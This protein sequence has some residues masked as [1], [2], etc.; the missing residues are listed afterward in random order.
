MAYP[1][2]AVQ[3]LLDDG[4]GTFPYDLTN[5]GGTSYLLME[6]GCSY[7]R[8]REDWQGGVTAGELSGEL[9]NSDGRF[10]PGNTT[11]ASPSPITVDQKARLKF[12]IP[13]T[14]DLVNLL[15]AAQASFEDG[16]TGGW[17]AAG[18]VLPTVA[19]SSVRAYDG[20][21]SLLV[22]WQ[23][24]GS[25]P[26]AQL[27]PSG[28]TIG[29]TYTFAVWVYVPSGSPDVRCGA[30]STVSAL[31]PLKDQWVRLSVTFVAASTT[32]TFFVRSSGTPAGATCYIDAAMVVAGSTIGDFNTVAQTTY[33]RFT[34]H[35]KSWPVA[36]PAT[37]STFATVRLSATDAQARAERRVLRSV[38]EEEILEDSPSAYYTLGEPADAVSAGDTS[39]AQAPALTQTGTGTNV[40]FGS[41]TGPGTD[42]LTAATFAG[43]QYL[44]SGTSITTSV[45]ECFFSRSGAPG[46][47]EVLLGSSGGGV[48]GI[49][50][51]GKIH[52]SAA[53]LSSPV[54]T[55]GATHHL[56]WQ[57]GHVLLDGVDI[58]S[59]TSTPSA[60]S[61]LTVGY[62][63]GAAGGPSAVFS[64]VIAHVAAFS[65]L[66]TTRG[67]A[68]AT[69]GSTG[70]AG[71]SG[72][73]RIT[74][75]AGYA[76]LPVGTLDTSLTNVAFIDFTNSEAWPTLQDAVDAEGG[77]AFVNGS[78]NLTFHNRNKVSLKTAPDLTLDKAYV[79]AD[80][81]P[82]TDDQQILNYVEAT[83]SA[84]G[85]PQL[86]R[87][88]TSETS[89]GRY[90]DS[91]TYLV[92]TDAEAL[93]RANWA[94]A[95]FAEPTTRYGTLTINLYRMT[96]AQQKTVLDALDINCW[97][98]ITSMPSQTPGSTTA[99]VV[100]EGWTEEVSSDSWLIRCNVVSR[101][102]FNVGIYDDATYGVFDSAVARYGV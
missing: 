5:M 94:I 9:N 27:Q 86:A 32:P 64:G 58:G 40:V 50:T 75:L 66:S 17:V 85:V 31:T 80:V 47:G 61:V 78:G 38:V 23:G 2:P 20:T 98:R 28:Y 33:T 30:G 29:N 19:N 35:V 52:T 97:L 76:N 11:I 41:A 55:D 90:S 25:N 39:G 8:G 51:D 46:T 65:T 81:Q 15:T 14:A 99:D 44:T 54:V 63:V 53:D 62:G 59:P 49:G 57:S 87:S 36:W 7:S 43:G 21:K 71:E 101:S 77:V 45:L 100:V 16:T 89:H 26:Q 96:L 91:K 10:T 22:T 73:A 93:D 60:T 83:A 92:L 1:L 79:T 74:R 6:S 37:V 84:T 69:A 88:T 24:S 12:T 13:P 48:I 102:L 4:T 56:S 67:A 95:N 72:T 82:V 3:F 68:H 34:G 18:T 70:F 42:G